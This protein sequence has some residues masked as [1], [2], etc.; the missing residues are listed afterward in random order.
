VEEE[1][2]HALEFRPELEEREAPPERA[3]ASDGF[4]ALSSNARLDDVIS[5]T[6]QPGDALL[7]FAYEANPEFAT[8]GERSGAEPEVIEP[9][10]EPAFARRDRL[11]DERAALVSQVARRRGQGHREV[12]GWINREVG[13]RSVADATADQL[14]RAVRRLER[15]LRR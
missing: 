10:A 3:P 1:R 4:T 9:A 15:E 7:L 14:E 5:S 13:I 12:N 2:R 11:R 8:P 6:T